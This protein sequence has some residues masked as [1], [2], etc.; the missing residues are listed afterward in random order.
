MDLRQ[1]RRGRLHDILRPTRNRKVRGVRELQRGESG[2][3]TLVE[4]VL[5]R[6]LL[7]RVRSFYPR[8]ELFKPIYTL[9][10]SSHH[11]PTER[12]NVP[13]TF[14]QIYIQVVFAVSLRQSLVEACYKHCPPTEG[15]E[16]LVDEHPGLYGTP[17]C[18]VENIA[19]EV[20]C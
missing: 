17:K 14:S 19:A 4:P 20:E 2:D 10:T 6:L 11:N 9:S 12:Q 1:V 7:R 16:V 5:Q 18:S 15:R 3:Q 13:N 8:V